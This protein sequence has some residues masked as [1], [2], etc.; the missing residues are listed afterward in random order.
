MGS[1]QGTRVDHMPGWITLWR[2]MQ[3]LQLMVQGADLAASLEK[4]GV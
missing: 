1:H 2:G 3:A 4:F